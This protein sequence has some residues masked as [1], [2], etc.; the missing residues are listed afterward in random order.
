LDVGSPWRKTQ[1]YVRSL[2][3]DKDDSAL[4]HQQPMNAANNDLRDLKGAQG[5]GLATPH[6]PGFIFF[7]LFIFISSRL[8]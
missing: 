2:G 5:G 8:P 6:L 7:N 4:S 3:L 1:I